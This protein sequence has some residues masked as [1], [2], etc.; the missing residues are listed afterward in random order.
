VAKTGDFK[1]ATDK[2]QPV[3][4][5]TEEG[6]TVRIDRPTELKQCKVRRVLF[7]VL[8]ESPLDYCAL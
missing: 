8:Q 1:L 5:R 4:R 3:G 2:P 6:K 7:L